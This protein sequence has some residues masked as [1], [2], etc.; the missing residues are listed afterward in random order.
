MPE[1]TDREAVLAALDRLM[2]WPELARS[3]QLT[4]FLEYIVHRRL[5]GD[6]QAIKA[7]SIAVDVFGRP[8]GFDPQSDP[9][10][11][12]QARR[13]RALLDQYYR[14]PGA[15]ETLQIRLPI[16]RYVPDFVGLT[17]DARPVRPT[18]SVDPEVEEESAPAPTPVPAARR[19]YVTVSWFVLLAIALAAA[20][21]AY[22]FSSWAPREESE[23]VAIGFIQQPHLR[24]M[25]VQ[26]L[27]GDASVTAAIS[28]LAIELIDRLQPLNF[29]E[30]SYGGH[31]D[32]A[33]PGPSDGY[34]LTGIV[35]R[36][37]SQPDDFQYSLALTDLSNN[38][39][40]W[41]KSLRLTGDQLSDPDRI[42]RMSIDVLAVLGN[43]RGPL[44]SKA[45][46]FLAEKSVIGGENLYLCRLLFTIY[47][48]V[49]TVGAAERAKS[50]YEA[51]P[52]SDRQTGIALAAM[53]SL[54][55]E[56][57]DVGTVSP[58]AQIERYA[59]ANNLL[60]KALE[61]L[62]T[63]SFVWEQRARLYEV[64][65]EHQ[66]AEAAY[67]TALQIN[68]AN[69]DALAAHARH[70]AL[71]GGLDHAIPLAQRALD[72][73]TVIPD[74]YYGVPTLAALRDGDYARAARFAQIY[75]RADRELGPI[76]AV[77]AA[78]GA[79]DEEEVARQL[80]RVL[81]VP[82]FRRVGIITQLR[83]RIPD[84]ALL[85]RF[86]E[87]LTAAGVPPMALVAA[88]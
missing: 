46:N 70:L 88:F 63:N 65:G 30:V 83:R 42:D 28:G 78:Q 34:V 24:I 68:P 27:T 33:A 40:V 52:E 54:I 45:R 48:E 84:E 76:L 50:C 13:L 29:V 15:E 6:S 62:P 58:T 51:L 37:P 67:G 81:A 17:P 66:Y 32:S 56:T 7:Y 22:M 82:S 39:V 18:A 60:T 43:P 25:E 11:R 14:G 80:P 41:N 72:A 71:M 86:R 38:S 26:N 1:V 74:W 64:M 10:V 21:L 61:L 2:T 77:M 5:E 16:G 79:G 85:D 57:I 20:A 47:R 44:H 12:V 8:A 19:G 23:R 69:I 55:A 53:A 75:A 59:E 4:R 87:A 31:R 49:S 3:P 73:H 35:R 36:D 9:I